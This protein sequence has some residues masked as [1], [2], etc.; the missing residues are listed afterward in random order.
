MLASTVQSSRRDGRLPCV[1]LGVKG[2][3]LVVRV[4]GHN[5]HRQVPLGPRHRLHGH[6]GMRPRHGDGVEAVH[7]CAGGGLVLGSGPVSGGRMRATRREHRRCWGAG[8]VEARWSRGR[9]GGAGVW[10]R[11]RWSAEGWARPTVDVDAGSRALSQP[12]SDT[13][14]ARR[15]QR[16]TERDGQWLNPR[17][18]QAILQVQLCDVLFLMCIRSHAVAAK[19]HGST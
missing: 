3:A 17:A 9:V 14:T 12:D 1:R 6:G 7:G 11:W 16:Q 10:W 5:G 2:R 15:A 13:G 19:T 8:G 18:H 4:H